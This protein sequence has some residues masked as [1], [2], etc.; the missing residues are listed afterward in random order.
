MMDYDYDSL[1]IGSEASFQVELDQAALA[2]FIALSGDTN[3]LH[4]DRAFARRRGFEDVVIPGQLL[5]AFYSR[6]AGVHLPGVNCILHAVDARF[7]RPAL[8]G[9]RVEVHGEVVA[10][11][12]AIRTIEIRAS[13]RDEGGQLLSRARIQAGFTEEA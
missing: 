13:I 9:M 12:D 8:L 2:A 5:G 10:K 3:P 11:H 4:N 1:A 6:L 7:M